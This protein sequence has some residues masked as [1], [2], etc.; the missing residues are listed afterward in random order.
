MTGAKA[1]VD[2]INSYIRKNCIDEFE[3]K[4]YDGRQLSIVGSTDLIYYHKI[5]ILFT[6]A[7]FVS[8]YFQRWY[9]NI[10]NSII[11]LLD[12]D[13]RKMANIPFE[14]ESGYELFMMKSADFENEMIVAAKTIHFN[15]DIVYFYRRHNLGFNERLADFLED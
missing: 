5:E 9:S 12:E 8:A 14:I 6:E 4:S 11:E 3:L 10:D 15:T 13:E 2:E 7:F 1:I